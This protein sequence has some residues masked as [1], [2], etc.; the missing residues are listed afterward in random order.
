[1]IQVPH[2]KD[3]AIEASKKAGKILMENFEKKK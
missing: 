2:F 1:V 3:I